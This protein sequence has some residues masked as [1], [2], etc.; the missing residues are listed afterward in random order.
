MSK[1][2]LRL[3]AGLVFGMML[4]SMTTSADPSKGGKILERVIHSGCPIPASRLAMSHSVEEWDAIVKAGKLDEEL[5]K[6]CPKLGQIKPLNKKYTQHVL[7]YLENYAN[8]SGAI[9]A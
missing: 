1:H 6:L 3:L 8:D 7:E 4:L 2:L 9:P 5:K